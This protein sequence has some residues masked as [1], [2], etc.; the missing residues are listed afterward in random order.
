MTHYNPHA[1]RQNGH[2]GP[3]LPPAKP[4]A[5]EWLTVLI[6]LGFL[7]GVFSL[8]MMAGYVLSYL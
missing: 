3:E 8:G 6:I 5:P 4:E 2:A 7:L 1:H